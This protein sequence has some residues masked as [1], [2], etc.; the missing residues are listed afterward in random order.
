MPIARIASLAFLPEGP[1][2]ARDPASGSAALRAQLEDG[3]RSTFLV[4]TPD[5]PASWA[6]KEG[7]SF[8]PPVLFVRRLDEETVAQA[9]QAMAAEMGGYWLRYYNFPG[10]GLPQARAARS[11]RPTGLEIVSTTVTEAYPPRSLDGCAVAQ[12][13]VADGREFSLLCATPAW[14]A[15]SF[16]QLRLDYFFGPSVL[17]VSRLKPKL[18]RQAVSALAAEGDRWLCRYDTPRR[19]LPELLADFAA[20]HARPEG[21]NRA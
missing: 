4:A 5:Q 11:R 12:A 8:G 1:A 2:V 14:F 9:A 13:A 18:A 15:R 20:R 6:A 21:T 3:K 7:W 17:F 10:A 16:E 19:T